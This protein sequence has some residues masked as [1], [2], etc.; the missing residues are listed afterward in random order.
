MKNQRLKIIIII[1]LLALTFCGVEAMAAITTSNDTGS[2]NQ[3][4]DLPQEEKCAPGPSPDA[5]YYS[6]GQRNAGVCG[7]QAWVNSYMKSGEILSVEGSPL[8]G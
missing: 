8:D 6:V 5:S 3:F 2:P 1:V 7:D 4:W